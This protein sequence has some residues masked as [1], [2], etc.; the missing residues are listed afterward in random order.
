MAWSDGPRTPQ[1]AGWR[2]GEWTQG[3]EA[4]RLVVP[5]EGRHPGHFSSGAGIQVPDW[6][7]ASAGVT[8]WAPA[9]AGATGLG[10]TVRRGDESI[11]HS[12]ESRNP[13]SQTGPRR[14][15]GRREHPSFR[16]KP[17][18]RIADWAPASAGAT[19][20]LTAD[21]FFAL[22]WNAPKF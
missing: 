4:I 22:P 7:P 9:S 18:S 20:L 6:T 1:S 10:S 13:E 12:G 8:D 16:R 14:P 19:V 15:P 2:W 11:R 17:E 3:E 5:A 21:R